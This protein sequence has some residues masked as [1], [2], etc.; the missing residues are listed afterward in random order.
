MSLLAA[1]QPPIGLLPRRLQDYDPPPRRYPPPPP[2]R[3]GC[4]ISDYM[5]IKLVVDFH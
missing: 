3:I 5:I 1:S 2:R 4:L